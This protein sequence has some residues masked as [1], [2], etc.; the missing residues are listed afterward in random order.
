[1][2]NTITFAQPL[3]ADF[4]IQN[5]GKIVLKISADGTIT[6]GDGF[7]PTEAGTLAIEA[8]R[9]A[10]ADIIKRAVDAET[11]RCCA[12]VVKFA[13]DRMIEAIRSKN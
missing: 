9:N 5:A 3:A 12:L 1:M 11:D 4:T 7:T 6:A 13:T 8:M 10:L 2:E